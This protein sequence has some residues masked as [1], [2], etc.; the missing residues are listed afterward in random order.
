MRVA[1]SGTHRTGKTTLVGAIC[2][3]EP[4]YE[5]FQEPYHLLEEEG[6]EFADPPCAEDFERQLRRSI[7]ILAAAPGD[8]LFDRCPL[9]FV[10]Y[11]QELADDFDVEDWLD[12]IRDRIEL[13]DLIV[14]VPIEEPDRISVPA[15]EDRRLRRRV[16]ER[17]RR[18][19][20]DDLYGFEVATLEVT[21]GLEERIHQVMRAM[22][23]A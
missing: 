3:L 10:A 14:V 16:D 13:L 6:Y 20:L 17:L 15:H 4:A 19:A 2:D 9:D 7:D 1:I 12:D 8:A 5:V 18:L 11:L 22:R 23:I 21:G